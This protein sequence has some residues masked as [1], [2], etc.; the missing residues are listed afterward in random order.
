M[1]EHEAKTG[2]AQ[3]KEDIDTILAKR[4]FALDEDDDDDEETEPKLQQQEE[5]PP[6]SAPISGDDDFDWDQDELDTAQDANDA[7]LHESEQ[8]EQLAVNHQDE[9]MAEQGAQGLF[10]GETT[11]NGD[12]DVANAVSQSVVSEP[13]GQS[14][15]APPPAET[16]K[17]D[18]EVIKPS[19]IDSEVPSPVIEGDDEVET[20]PIVTNAGIPK[21]ID[22]TPISSE[23]TPENESTKEIT[24]APAEQKVVPKSAPP[25]PKLPTSSQSNQT[26]MLLPPTS[27]LRKAATAQT[28]SGSKP[29][30]RPKPVKTFEKEY[31]ETLTLAKNS[32]KEARTL[33]RHVVAL[34][35]ELENAETEITAQ[36]EELDRAGG[37]LEKDRKKYKEEK[38]KMMKK[39]EEEIKALK[40]Q[41]EDIVTDLKSRNDGLLHEAQAKMRE[42]EDKRAQEGGDWTKELE[43]TIHREQELIRKVAFL[44]DEKSTLMAQI[45]TLQSKQDQLQGRLDSI[46]QTADNAML[47]E[48]EAE[49]KLDMAMS[50][51]ARQLS[52]RQS[53]ESE[54]E[55]TISELTGALSASG[56]S[57]N[58]LSTI[59]IGMESSAGIN[60]VK[61]EL[62]N[63]QEELE[64]MKVKLDAEK[65]RVSSFFIFQHCGLR[66]SD[67]IVSFF[68]QVHILQQELR[69]TSKERA[70]EA[71]AARSKQLQFDKQIAEYSLQIS[72]LQSSLREAKRGPV[73]EDGVS[74]RIGQNDRVQ[75]L[76][77]ELVRLQGKLGQSG[78]EVSALKTRLKA[79]VDRAENAEQQALQ[80]NSYDIERGPSSGDYGGINVGPTTR[81]R[82]RRGGD[83]G[84]IRNTIGLNNI[85]DERAESIGKAIDAVDRFAVDTGK[86]L[87]YNPLAR[88]GFVLYLIMLHLWTFVVLFFHTHK[89][90]T[91]EGHFGDRLP[92]GPHAMMQ[93]GRAHPDLIKL[94]EEMEAG[95]AMKIA[96]AN[97]LGPDS[98]TQRKPKTVPEVSQEAGTDEKE[99]APDKQAPTKS[100]GG[101]TSE[102]SEGNEVANEIEG[103]EIDS[104]EAEE[105]IEIEIKQ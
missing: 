37:Q 33:R 22:E 86:F 7:E 30:S 98:E 31:R 93:Q 38:Q 95:R 4:G 96:K 79:A 88:G 34:N 27:A 25:P 84:S 83:Y 8:T 104:T 1:E 64:T 82:R 45:S 24:E 80:S 56:L 51:H 3:A 99:K 61:D 2:P 54:L 87:R 5:V 17:I 35:S 74:E 43:H 75:E 52:Q 14:V 20:K 63:T 78:S 73:D 9:P 102:R 19:E 103:E 18:E 48:R 13:G 53:R 65:Q 67:L 69:D 40:Q 81:R 76:T 89:F 55:R 59:R 11:N 97:A 39:H 44:D 62:N 92:H 16:P 23:G 41:Q 49:D 46:S 66:F 71:S 105:D 91:V 47:R 29:Q 101:K 42:L 90:G 12:A 28:S 72:R 94:K 77:R 68:A 10:T 57:D 50:M 32:Q 60:A 26:K 70:G 58:N 15:L 36:R 85:R 100:T 6:E 21:T